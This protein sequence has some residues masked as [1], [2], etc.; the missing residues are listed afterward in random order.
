ML[1]RARARVC[2]YAP[3]RR[4]PGVANWLVAIPFDTVKTRFQT[5][6]DGTYKGTFDCFKRV[7]SGPGGSMN[8]FRGAGPAMLRAFPANAACF[9]GMELSMS[10]LTGMGMD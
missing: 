9:F 4:G 10:L 6:P 2:A 1:A 7:V 8:L 5:A 3:A